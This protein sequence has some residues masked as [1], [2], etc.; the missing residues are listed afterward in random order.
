M[1][2]WTGLLVTDT[3]FL[4]DYQLRQFSSAFDPFQTGLVSQGVS[5]IY[6]SGAG[7]RSYFDIRSIYYYG[8]SEFDNQSQIPIIH[9]VLDYSNVLPQQ[10]LGGELSYKINL[11]SLSRQQ[12]EF[13]AVNATAAANQCLR[14][15]DRRYCSAGELSIARHPG[16]LYALLRAGGLAAHDIH[17]QWPDDHALLPGPRRLCLARRRQ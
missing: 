10:L 4:Y 6:L 2:G 13:D 7:A 15:P 12:A 11:T 5:Q 14:E 16:R 17:R 9:P 8:F 1:W 3:Q